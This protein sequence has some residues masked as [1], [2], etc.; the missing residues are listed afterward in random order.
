MAEAYL[1]YSRAA[2]M[3]PYNATYW[4]RS[5]AVRTRAALEAKVMPQAVPT[6]KP[7]EGATA[8]GETA[9]GETP[10]LDKATPDDIKEARKPLPPAELKAKPGL[11]DFDLRENARAIFEK[12]AA[13]YGLDCVFDGDYAPGSALRFR[14]EGVDYRDA[15][16][17]A[18]A[19][20]GSFIVPLA[21]RLFLVAKDTAEKRASLEPS[22][23]VSVRLPEATNQQDFTGLVTAVQQAMALEKVSFDS[24]QNAI[25]LHDRI[26]KVLPARA[27]IEDLLYPRGQV[28]I[29]VKFQEVSR[30]DLL[31]YGIDLQNAFTI[32]PLTTIF[33]NKPSLT[34]IA[35]AL[36]FG[37]GQSLMGIGVINP[38]LM[39]KLETTQ[40]SSSQLLHAEM[41]SVDGQPATLHVGDRYPI[42]T[43]GYYGP[44]TYGTAGG[45]GVYTPPP[46]FNYEDLGL[47]LKVTP[48]VH[49]TEDATLDIDATFKV[50]SGAAL[51]GIPVISSRSLKSKV[52]L[53]FGEWAAVA[54]LMNNSE[55]RT[56]SGIAGL[57][58][59]PLLGNLTSMRD[60]NRSGDQVLILMRPR[61]ITQPPDA[62]VTHTFRVGTDT[63]PTTPL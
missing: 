24:Q 8:E 26:S 42:M 15:L 23:A 33:N 35:A 54:G 56:M 6:A 31:T 62:S 21:E 38:A 43:G 5:Q 37:G 30:N 52:T 32:T 9:E 20:T 46:S 55:A 51:N 25:I 48:A 44:S 11:H 12:V 19:A 17:A 39:L 16:H 14:L 49:G 41:R 57:A 34:G 58:R 28:T 18:E 40:S 29:D 22:V 4:L 63:R 53:E 27:L 59:V 36:A 2:A 45:A 60:R 47:A 3:E 10:A 13:A 1:L 7:A 50:L 61:L